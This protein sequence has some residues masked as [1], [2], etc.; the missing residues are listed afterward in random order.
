MCPTGTLTVNYLTCGI[1]VL[2]TVFVIYAKYVIY[3]TYVY[4]HMLVMLYV[5]YVICG[6]RGLVCSRI[7]GNYIIMAQDKVGPGKGGFLNNRLCSY[8]EIDLCSEIK[9]YVYIHSICFRKTNDY[10]GNHLY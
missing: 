7:G 2:I 10:S 5:E 1:I 8:T 9:W 4:K 3:C 6:L